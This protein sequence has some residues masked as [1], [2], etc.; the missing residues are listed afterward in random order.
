MIYTP[1]EGLALR[2][3]WSGAQ[4]TYRAATAPAILA[5]FT[6]SDLAPCPQRIR[7]VDFR[8]DSAR[9]FRFLRGSR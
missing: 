8:G 1:P 5:P 3:D 7:T 9:R 2:P 4:I 6:T